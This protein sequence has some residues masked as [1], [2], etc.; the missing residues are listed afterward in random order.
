MRTRCSLAPC[1]A[2]CSTCTI[3]CIQQPAPSACHRACRSWRLHSKL[4]PCSTRAITC[5]QQA[6]TLPP[7]LQELGSAA[8]GL[9]QGTKKDADQEAVGK[10]CC[11]AT[12]PEEC[13]NTVPQ[14]PCCDTKAETGERPAPPAG[15][16]WSEDF[17]YFLKR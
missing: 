17:P 12:P 4:A 7:C 11:A 14:D 9:L 10:G 13:C 8:P 15:L 3:A 2:S 1:T 5:I 6:V 16:K